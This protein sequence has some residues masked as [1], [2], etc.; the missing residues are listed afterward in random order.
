MKRILSAAICLA[1][2]F[3]CV[4]AAAAGTVVFK[5]DPNSSRSL[6]TAAYLNGVAYL[7]FYNNEIAA[8]ADDGQTTDWRWA[9]DAFAAEDGENLDVQ[10][11]V[12]DGEKLRALIVRS[13]YDQEDESSRVRGAYLY[14]LEMDDENTIQLGE[15]VKLDWDDMIEGYDEY[16]YTRECEL[17]FIQGGKLVFL[18]YG[19]IGRVAMI[20]DLESGDCQMIEAQTLS[21][22]TPYK[23]G[24]ALGFLF[25]YDAQPQTVAVADVDLTSGDMETNVE[26]PV[27]DYS[28][29][30]SP[31]YDAREDAV[32]YLMKGE[33]W[34]ATGMDFEN[35]QSICAAR[36]DGRIAQPVRTN[37]GAL[38]LCSYGQAVK[39]VTDPGNRPSKRLS[40]AD[41]GGPAE[42]AES[43]F[44][45][46][47]PDVEIIAAG[48]V[49]D[50]I[51]AMTS[52]S[53]DVDIYGCS[54][55]DASYTALFGRGYMADLSGSEKLTKLA[56]GLYDTIQ[57]AI[58]RDGKLCALPVY[59]YASASAC[60]MPAFEKAGLTEADIPV[61]WMDFLTMLNNLP[62]SVDG[63]TISAFE[64]MY[65]I[66]GIRREL[67]DRILRS[68]LLNLQGGGEAFDAQK[69]TGLFKALDAVDFEAL[70]VPEKLD[71]D[72][73]SWSDDG[74]LFGSG[75]GISAY[76]YTLTDTSKPML[77][78]LDEGVP[79]MIP[80]EVQVC[81]VNP[82]SKNVDLAVEYLECMA[83]H[84]EESFLVQAFPGNNEPVLDPYFEENI[85]IID[86][87]IASLKT[88]LENAEAEDKTHLTE[89]LKQME[90]SRAQYMEEGRYSISEKSIAN[91]RSFAPLLRVNT[92]MGMDVKNA[93]EINT[94]VSQFADRA[95]DAETLVREMDN[96]LRMMMMET[97]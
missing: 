88:N 92:N 81:F 69:L 30:A 11:V 38:L 22:L 87:Y 31:C 39:Y 49:S 17:P 1:L 78:A 20:Y 68:Y 19:D 54:V 62:E 79:A 77:L 91:Y 37:D 29:P 55:S 18:S 52:Q 95:I 34:K 46:A 21:A 47:H 75:S 23:D 84:M 74:V 59:M 35:A 28:F 76:T 10:C 8:V 96:K 86:E 66:P 90:E 14:D 2:L 57:N 94:L 89:E 16:E 3:S 4:G 7:F 26:F 33:L 41:F 13:E 60:S 48:Y 72:S 5:E 71:E 15:R 44:V 65:D 61:T 67:A 45:K 73:F 27:A 58:V 32:Y 70:G 93:E 64:P 42:Q 6:R 36:E 53:S 82:Y 83:D 9:E 12:S 97:M 85:K 43:D 80:L 63:T 25:N 24:R 51:S 40:I 56:D 50:I